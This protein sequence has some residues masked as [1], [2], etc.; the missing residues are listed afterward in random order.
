MRYSRRVRRMLT[1]SLVLVTGIWTA[2][3][4]AP[5]A[6]ASTG[7]A[8]ASG[9][10][11]GP[12]DTWLPKPAAYP[13]E[14][15]LA[16]TPPMGFNDWANFE[17]DINQQLFVNTAN[18]LVSTG[19]AKDGYRYVNID[20]CWSALHRNAHGQ[21]VANP[22]LFPKGLKWLGD[23]LHARGL[24]FGIYE[25]AGTST[26][27]GWPGSWGHWQQDA[28]T[29]ASWGVD[30]LKLD[31][32]NVPSVTGQS[33]EQT[34]KSAYTQMSQ[35]LKA[36]GRPIVF[37][38]SAPAY[39]YGSPGFTQI[40]SWVGHEGNL[41]RFG[42][43]VADNWASILTN[44]SEANSYHLASYAGPGHWNDPDMLEVNN[45]GL[46]STEQQ[47]QFSL[48][49]EMAAPLL[50]STDMTHL[51]A[52]A[53]SILANKAV[54]AVDQDSYGA[55][56]TIVKTE[57]NIDILAKPL[58][59]GDIAVVLFNKGETAA[60]ASISAHDAGFSISP[61]A[62]LLDNLWTH[63][64][65]ETS[66]AIAANIPAHGV[67]MYRI[68]PV[69][70]AHLAPPA[71]VMSIANSALVAGKPTPVK[72]TLTD[73]GLLPLQNAA[74]ALSLPAGWTATATSPTSFATV[75]PGRSV[76]ASYLVTSTTPPPGSTVEFSTASGYGW[77]GGSAQQ[78]AAIESY[79]SPTPYP[80][81]AAAFNNIAI[82]NESNT[83]PAN[84]NGGFDG[85]NDTYSQQAL[86]VA[87]PVSGAT[88]S[89]HGAPG[90]TVTYNG[91]TF[92]IP[93]VAADTPDNVSGNGPKIA[94]SGSGS[95]IAFLGSEAGFTQ[96]T[97]TV[98]YTDGSTSTAQLGFPNWCCATQTSYGSVPVLQTT[99]RDT[100]TGPAD[101]G[102]DYDLFYNTIPI[103]A[104][105]TVATVTLPGNNAIHIFGIAIKP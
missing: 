18:A 14:N 61:P 8:H 11:S 51:S 64:V 10:V 3:V 47:S 104:G 66:S 54:L 93:N 92:T 31:G 82:T 49:A 85:G 48:W 88:L 60:N 67:V 57:G 13:S 6:T 22:S 40:M 53:Q 42:S 98:T 86:N 50:I 71:T 19:L 17:C 95:A 99:H 70:G 75:Q 5:A 37:S 83:N 32:C 44:Y 52:Q 94:L 73:D 29:F 63:R 102:I 96:D 65:T 76:T 74:V 89:N 23:Y 68:T 4:A 103:T 55:Q 28:D 2:T 78:A 90:S 33:A 7:T 84:L 35:A 87:T 30:Y 39:F 25:D 43:D 56:G 81:L 21:L 59:N 24:K 34:Y 12:S 72:A 79:P 16:L 9:S 101:Y 105:K 46:S 38:E 62:Y 69:A 58:E 97:V 41:W 91:V 80:N 100:P 1:G 77:P 26:C 20:D 15:G 36:T 27:G 45:P